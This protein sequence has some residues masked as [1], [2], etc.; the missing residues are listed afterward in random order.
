MLRRC[1]TSAAAR[2]PQPVRRSAASS[3]RKVEKRDALQ[4]APEPQPPSEYQPPLE[5]PQPTMGQELKSSFLWGIGMAVGFSMLG[6]V[7][8]VFM[9]E[10]PKD[11]SGLVA[12]DDA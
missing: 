3:R 6:V 8:R 12:S 2:R 10:A 4:A 1:M 7:A 9:E 11:P 5:M